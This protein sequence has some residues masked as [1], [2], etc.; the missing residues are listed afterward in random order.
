MN[1]KMKHPLSFPAD[2][3]GAPTEGSQPS[4]EAA[5]PSSAP[6]VVELPDTGQTGHETDNVEGED[7]SI[8]WAAESTPAQEEP[9]V[10]QDDEPTPP[11]APPKPPQKAPAQTPK[12]PQ[13]APDQPPAQQPDAAQPPTEEPADSPTEEEPQAAETP[14]Q[15]TARETQEKAER[16]R[17]EKEQFAKLVEYYKIPDDMA[18]RLSTE[19]EL[20]LP[21][22]AAKIH[23]A[24]MRTSL[25]MLAQELPQR[26]EQIQT[27]RAAEE[28]S[29]EA[30]YSRWPG[31]KGHEKQVLQVGRMYRQMNPKATPEQAIEKIGRVVNA[32]L[33]LADTAPPPGTPPARQAQPPA[34]KSGFRPAGTQASAAAAT[35]PSDNVF[36]QM[37]EEFLLE[38]SEP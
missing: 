3:T 8:D 31:L 7:S 27:Y 19:P 20:V 12:P 26:I 9:D 4:G 37:A 11:P 38:D 17:V 6:T 25:N 35:P 24:L 10:G 16:E 22:L 21:V 2:S 29:K 32:A 36:A 5:A 34:A 14:E 30:F 13:K 1:L 15:R 28:K 18:A 23:Q 33:G